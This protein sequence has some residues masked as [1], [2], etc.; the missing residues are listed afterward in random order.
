MLR[1]TS[2]AYAHC[3]LW[4]TKIV[5]FIRQ[6]LKKLNSVFTLCRLCVY[7]C[8]LSFFWEGAW[9]PDQSL[10]FPAS[11][12]LELLGRLP[13]AKSRKCRPAV[14]KVNVS[15]SEWWAGKHNQESQKRSK[16]PQARR[17]CLIQGSVK[18]RNW[19]AFLPVIWRPIVDIVLLIDK[20]VDCHGPGG[21]LEDA[22]K[23]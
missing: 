2:C 3:T 23:L 22:I 11:V 10:D 15:S 6:I 5:I 14:L 12:T 9:Y 16:G 8:V 19:R 18:G 7:V 13:E 1:G 20:T 21:G 4:N 17:P